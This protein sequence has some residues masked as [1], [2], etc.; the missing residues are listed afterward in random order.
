MLNLW[1]ML[2]IEMLDQRGRGGGHL[3]TMICIHQELFT[4]C[5]KRTFT[6][7]CPAGF[8]LSIQLLS[9]S[10]TFSGGEFDEMTRQNQLLTSNSI[11][12]AMVESNAGK[13]C[14]LSLSSEIDAHVLVQ[15]CLL[16]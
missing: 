6:M 7:Y 5:F 12:K 9:I 2:G 1:E 4:G 16:T 11:K 10:V 14:Y 13:K 15:Y 3:V 8:F